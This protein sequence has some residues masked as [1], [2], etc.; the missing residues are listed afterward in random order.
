M[1]SGVC[2]N[3][4]AWL[5]K[6]NWN[7]SLLLFC[8]CVSLPVK[9][10][11][12]KCIIIKIQFILFIIIIYSI[13]YLI[14]HAIFTM[15]SNN[16]FWSINVNWIGHTFSPCLFPLQ[17]WAGQW[18]LLAWCVESLHVKAT[19]LSYDVLEVMSSW[20]RQRTTAAPMTRSV[21]RIPSRWRMFSAT[22]QTP[23]K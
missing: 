3:W 12:I 15:W 1:T 18:C 20:L 23:L 13:Y 22:C 17:R 8:L 21:T 2:E 19:R 6:Q 14:L 16:E 5:C 7:I 11:L 10:P 9:W 4:I